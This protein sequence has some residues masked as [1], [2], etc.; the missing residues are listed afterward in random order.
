M[1]LDNKQRDQ[2]ARIDSQ[3]DSLDTTN[4]EA[5]G[6]SIVP[7]S[8]ED[9]GDDYEPLPAAGIENSNQKSPKKKQLINPLYADSDSSEYYDEENDDEDKLQTMNMPTARKVE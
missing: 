2:L 5:N 4:K 9:G 7:N 1:L 6:S 3:F 8:E